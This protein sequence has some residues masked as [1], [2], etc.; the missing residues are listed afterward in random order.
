MHSGTKAVHGF[1]VTSHNAPLIVGMMIAVV[2]LMVN[3]PAVVR[4]KSAEVLNNGG[5]AKMAVSVTAVVRPISAAQM[6]MD[7]VDGTNIRPRN[8]SKSS[9]P[10]VTN[11]Q[12]R[13]CRRF[14]MK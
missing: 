2:L 1:P 6:T 7:T 13:R 3:M 10:K 14:A 9:G 5:N 8:D 4:G 12:A 11:G